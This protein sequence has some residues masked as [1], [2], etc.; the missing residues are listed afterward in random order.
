M[1]VVEHPRRLLSG[2]GRPEGDEGE[3]HA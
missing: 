3:W 1:L 2:R